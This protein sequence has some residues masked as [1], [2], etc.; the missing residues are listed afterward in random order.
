MTGDLTRE[1]AGK[2]QVLHS[3][4]APVTGLGFKSSG[5]TSHLFVASEQEVCC[6]NITF[7]DREHQVGRLRSPTTAN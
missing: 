2:H 6:Y 1:R 5:K 4:S 7:K 3:G